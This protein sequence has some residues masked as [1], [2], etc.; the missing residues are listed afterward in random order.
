MFFLMFI[1]FPVVR[2]ASVENND[3]DNL[4]QLSLVFFKGKY[5]NLEHFVQKNF[6]SKEKK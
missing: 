4:Y 6:R 1:S 5:K 3:I 2:I